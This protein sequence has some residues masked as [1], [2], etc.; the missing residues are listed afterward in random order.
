MTAMT[1][2]TILTSHHEA[3]YDNKLYDIYCQNPVSRIV[4]CC[5]KI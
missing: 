4:L 2:V 5:H 1:A 3:V